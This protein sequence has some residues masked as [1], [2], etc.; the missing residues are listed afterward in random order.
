MFAWITDHYEDSPSERRLPDHNGRQMQRN[1]LAV[2][3]R[4]LHRA[5]DELEKMLGRTKPALTL[6]LARGDER[7]W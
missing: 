7:R 2:T 6:A 1:R 3:F 4:H 5:L